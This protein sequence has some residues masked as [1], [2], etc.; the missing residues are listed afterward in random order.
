MAAAAFTTRLK[1][2]G[3]ISPS[4]ILLNGTAGA[5]AAD[6]ISAGGTEHDGDAKFLERLVT[7]LDHETGITLRNDG[8]VSNDFNEVLQVSQ[9]NGC[10][11]LL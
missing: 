3:S 4:L 11:I 10:L 7:L 6:G 9:S 5:S 1:S 8:V 2:S